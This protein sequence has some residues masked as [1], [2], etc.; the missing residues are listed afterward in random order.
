M[1]RVL[2]MGVLEAVALIRLGLV[3][4]RELLGKFPEGLRDL[5]HT[6]MA[7]AMETMAL[8]ATMAPEVYA[9]YQD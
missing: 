2:G 9:R 3:A 5:A 6:P 4:L 7:P 1:A 8:T